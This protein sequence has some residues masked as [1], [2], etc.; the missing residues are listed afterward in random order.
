M[1]ANPHLHQAKP[2]TGAGFTLIELL[3]VIAIIA[4]LAALLLPALARA[5]EK[6]HRTTCKSNMRQ[7]VLG[8]LMYSGENREHF[9]DNTRSDNVRHASW[10]SPATY[11]YF[12]Q[13]LRVQTNCFTC[14][15]KN[16]DGQWIRLTPS[17]TRMGFYCLWG[18]PTRLDARP[19]DRDYG[20]QPAPFDSPQ[21]STDLTLF[22]VLMAD[23]IEKGTD[24]LGTA[25]R[26]TSAPHTPTGARASPSG[27]LVEPQIIG[28]DGGNVA[29]PDGA[30]GW[31]RQVVM[32][33]RYVVYNAPFT[34]FNANP[35]YLGYW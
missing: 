9:P 2:T 6:A 28:S 27:Q 13:T 26:V 1:N 11:N 21:K 3:V 8:A 24:T 35:N 34:S 31:R 10:I 19:R 29:T 7:V 14:P 32:R 25:S 30:V 17:G 22:S 5:K 12:V 4:I 15:N 23:I 18:L 20:T 33:P 16:K